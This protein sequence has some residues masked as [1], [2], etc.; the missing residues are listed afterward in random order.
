VTEPT[1]ATPRQVVERFLRAS[2]DNAWDDLAD[3]YAPDALIDL[4][5]A[6]PDIPRRFQGREDHRARFKAVAPL[7]R[8]NRVDAVVVHET[9]DPEVVLVEFDSHATVT[10]TGRSF[11]NSYA[12]VMRIRKGL[13]VSSRDYANPL[14]GA[15][16]RK[17]VSVQGE[18]A[19]NA[20][21]IA[22]RIRRSMEQVAATG[23]DDLDGLFAED[24]FYELPFAPPGLPRRVEGREEIV[25]YLSAGT[26]RALALG[27]KKVHSVVHECADPEIAVLELQVE[28]ES[29]ATGDS[30][31]FDSSIGV[32][33]VRDGQIL[34]WRDYPN[35]IGGAAVSG[36]LPQ[37][38]AMLNP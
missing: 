18:R 32:I 2:A 5:F 23:T 33:R 3:L 27:I 28:G 36:T 10:S 7:R 6:P 30:F 17:E 1:A 29:P 21:E 26:K 19:P 12:M 37:L 13:I 15:E 24:A 4:P 16:L 11:V 8:I 22:E 9:T 38:A 35:I 20:R 31:R 14:D 34:S 25:A